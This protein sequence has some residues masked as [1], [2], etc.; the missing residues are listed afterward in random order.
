MQRL[1]GQG[2]VL[3]CCM[4]RRDGP[5]FDF[6]GPLLKD[7]LMA[8]PKGCV[9]HIALLFL[10]AGRHAGQGGDIADIIHGVMEKRQDLS[11]QTTDIMAGHPGLNQLLMKRAE[12]GIP[13]G[14]LPNFSL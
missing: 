10:Q 11:V 8:L 4:E 6:N 5:D 12:N 9:V 1:L 14:L 7:A 2:E 3:G 13:L